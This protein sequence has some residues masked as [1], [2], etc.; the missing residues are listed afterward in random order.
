MGQIGQ[1]SL[2]IWEV[3]ASWMAGNL[4]AKPWSQGSTLQDHNCTMQSP[5]LPAVHLALRISP[6]LTYTLYKY[7]PLQPGS[8]EIG[9]GTQNLFVGSE[10]NI[11]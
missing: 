10:K 6:Q 9:D 11:Y 8:A 1:G 2:K 5:P 3:P 7:I 4:F